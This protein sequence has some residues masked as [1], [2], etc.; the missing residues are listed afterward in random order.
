MEGKGIPLKFMF[1]SDE[2]FPV[3]EE[4]M[5]SSDSVAETGMKLYM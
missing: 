1:S 4:I 2:I 5:A 3:C